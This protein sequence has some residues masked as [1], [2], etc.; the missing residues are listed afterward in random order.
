MRD[1]IANIHAVFTEVAKNIPDANRDWVSIA[2][3]LTY[4]HIGTN[5][6][7]TMAASDS[8]SLAHLLRFRVIHSLGLNTFIGLVVRRDVT[9][10]HAYS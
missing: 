6:K 5:A 4:R 7:L 3:I 2:R 10:V 8:E 1:E 9:Y